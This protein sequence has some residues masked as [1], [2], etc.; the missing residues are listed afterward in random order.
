MHGFLICAAAL[1]GSERAA[2]TNEADKH[3]R[4]EGADINKSLLALK[5][6][7][8]ALDKEASHVPFRGSKLTQACCIV[9][10]LYAFD[11]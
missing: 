9:Y 7:V 1:A 8:R 10:Y 6:C 11:M 4:L 3:T 5:E 2:D